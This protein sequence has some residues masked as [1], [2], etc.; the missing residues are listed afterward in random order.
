MERTTMVRSALAT[1]L[2]MAM[3]A[4]G[5][6]G[7]GGNVRIDPPP[8]TPTPPTT[9]PPTAPPPAKPQEPAFD[10][11]LSVTNARAA[12]AAGLTGQGVRIGIVDSGVQRN[13][14]ALNGRVVGNLNY[15]D[16]ARNNLLVD[17]VVGHGTAVASLAAGAPV[18][19]WPGGI[20]PGAQIVSARIIA[21]KPPV[22]DGSGKGNSFSGPLGVAQVHQDLISYN[23]KVMNNSWGGLYW[24]DLPTTAQVAA[25]YRPFVINHGGLVVFAAGNDARTEPSSL[26]ALPSQLGVAGSLPAADLERGWLVATAV[27]PYAPGTLASYANACGQAARYCLAAPGSAVYPDANGSTYYWNYGTSFAAP[28]IS[29]AA[30]LVWQRYPYFDNNLVRQTLLGT[31]KDIGAPGV[32]AVFGYGLLDISRAIK[33]PGRFDWG[34]VVASVDA[35]SSGSL[36]SN[37]IVGSGGLV[38]QGGGTLVL[39]G[40]NSYSGA[41]RIERGILSLQNGGV[42]RSNVTILGQPDPDSTGLQF[43]GG[44]PR[45]IGNVVNGSSVFLTTGSTTGTIEGNYTQQAG[46][47][48]MIALGA[49]ALQVTGTASINGGVRVHGFVSGYVPQNGSRQDLV[50]AAGGLSGTFSSPASSSGLQGLSLLQS[51]YGYD[52]NTAWLNLTQVSVTAAATG[53]A[54]SAQSAAQRLEGAFSALDGSPALQGSAFGTAAGALQWTGGGSEGLAASLQS[55]SGQ[56]HARAESATFDSIDMSRRAIAE[57]FDRVQAAPRLRGAWQSALGEAGQ[58]SFAGNAADSRGWMAGQDLPLGSNGL[59]GVAFGETRSNGGSSFGGDRGRDR[60]AQAQLYAGWNLGRGY[61]LAQVGSGQFT[62]ALDRQL[63]LGAGAYGVSARYG[64][65][66]SSASV[67]GG[68]RFGRAGASLTPYLGASTT[69]VDTDAFNELGGF[70]F[71]LRGDANRV[72]RSQMLAGIRGERGWGR[73]TLRGHAEWQQRLD[74]ADADWQASFVGVDAWAPLAGWDAPRGSALFGVALESWWGRNGRLSL[75]F[76]QR[77]GGEGARQAALRYSTGF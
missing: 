73:W 31:A 69:R 50:H 54:A 12:Q 40:N 64:G 20:A 47:Q 34:D 8:T 72:Q 56:A 67:E 45:V 27:D 3:T 52:S 43:N 6:G 74:G 10:A 32:D 70:G 63:L 5:G 39:A 66:F 35:P 71:G 4:C 30:A 48:L 51:S 9:P 49:N 76:D 57:R 15:I 22:D 16:P 17:D 75:G 13:A 26:A 7:G 1:A 11:H 62:R 46:G 44:T 29:G 28:L 36:W 61:A 37:D 19:T 18:G 59:M 55:L 25:E 68:Y 24:T 42:I 65:R 21:D 38:K 14:A 58:G 41:T 23:V 2:A 53:L 33:G 60:Q 77:V